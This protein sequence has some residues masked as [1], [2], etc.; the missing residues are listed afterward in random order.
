MFSRAEREGL[1]PMTLEPTEKVLLT[2]LPSTY[3]VGVPFITPVEGDRRKPGVLKM[4]VPLL[5]G[6]GPGWC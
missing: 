3:P 6:W 2:L 1:G 4:G 5:E